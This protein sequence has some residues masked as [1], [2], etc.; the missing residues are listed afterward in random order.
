MGRNLK[1]II[2]RCIGLFIAGDGKPEG[3]DVARMV[4]VGICSGSRLTLIVVGWAIWL[5]V[6]VQ[7]TYRCN[8]G[9]MHCLEA[10]SFMQL[11]LSHHNFDS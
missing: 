2:V 5:F 9:D 4:L 11:A 1:S 7:Y 3:G 8:I 6:I 10:I